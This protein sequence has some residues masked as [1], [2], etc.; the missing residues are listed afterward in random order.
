MKHSFSSLK[1]Y[2]QCPRQYHEVKVLKRWPRVQ[3]EDQKFGEKL[4]EAFELFIA[5]NKPLAPE[6][7]AYQPLLDSVK[8]KPGIAYAE[9]HMALTGFGEYCEWDD[10]RA[11]LIGVADYVRVHEKIGVVIDWKAGSA[12]Y[13]D[14]EQ[15]EL[16]SLMLMAKHQAIETVDAALVFVVHNEMR[17]RRYTRADFEWLQRKWCVQKPSAVEGSTVTSLWPPKPSPLCPW[18][19]VTTCEFWRPKPMKKR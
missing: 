16:M 10:S 5:E 3:T 2:A 13:P 8:S 15:L 17:K 14:E 9:L 4:H 1:V 19:P 18:C 11:H 7:A 12:K 6:F